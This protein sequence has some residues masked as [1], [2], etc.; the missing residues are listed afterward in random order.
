MRISDWS[1]DV[2]S[3]DLAGATIATACSGAVVLAETGLLDGQSATTHWAYCDGLQERHPD[4][5][6]QGDRALVV[7]GEGQRLLMAGGGASWMDLAPLLI[8]RLPGVEAAVR[9]APLDLID[10]HDGGQQQTGR[11]SGR[12]RLGN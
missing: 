7:A 10:W 1:S 4:I 8:S 3:S 5:H 6:V 2:C 11:T 12:G 9:L